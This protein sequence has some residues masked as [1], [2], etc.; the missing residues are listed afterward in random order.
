MEFFLFS[1]SVIWVQKKRGEKSSFLE[2]H[3]HCRLVMQRWL[4]SVR[5]LSA[6]ACYRKH[7]KSSGKSRKRR[8]QRSEGSFRFIFAQENLV[9]HFFFFFFSDDPHKEAWKNKKINSLIG[10]VL[11]HWPSRLEGNGHSSRSWLL[12]SSRFSSSYIFV[13]HRA[14][15][16]NVLLFY[17]YYSY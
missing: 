2:A 7:N 14:K 5:R 11:T 9:V 15:K 1:G 12:G 16:K 6:L 10:R 13:F 4:H 17:Y 8:S 3:T